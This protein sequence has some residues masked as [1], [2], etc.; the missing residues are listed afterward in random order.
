MPPM[1]IER[2]AKDTGF[3]PEYDTERAVADYLAWLK[4]GNV[5]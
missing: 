3:A 4:A 5:H 1:N 2:L